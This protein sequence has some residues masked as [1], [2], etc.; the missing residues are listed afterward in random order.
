MSLLA[1]DFRLSARRLLRSPGFALVAIATLALGIG[2]NTSI[3]S[4]VDAALIRALPY[5]NADRVVRIYSP[6]KKGRNSSV[7]PPDFTDWRAASTVFD[8][9]AAISDGAYALTGDGVAEEVDAANVTQDFFTILGTPPEAGRTFAA[10]DELPDV[11]V[12]ILSDGLWRRRFGADRGLIGRSIFLDA[13][14]YTVIGVMP[15]GF[16]YPEGD[17]IW[18]PRPFNAHD[19][20]TQRGAHYLSV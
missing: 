12:V 4:V 10:D 13:V 15:P 8:G 19:L 11:H 1:N 6:S 16:D 7:S 14:P 9:M 2:A 17:G 20:A 3:F 18:T 5:P